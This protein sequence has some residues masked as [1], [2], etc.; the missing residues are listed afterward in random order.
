[1]ATTINQRL[2]EFVEEKKIIPSDIYS[3]IGV[4]RIQW[5]NWFNAGAPISLGKLQLIIG[6]LP[7]VNVRW[8][9]TGEIANGEG[10]IVEAHGGECKECVA[11]QRQIDAL[12][13]H[14]NTLKSM[15]DLLRKK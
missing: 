3:K 4:T 6:L 15:I 13:D 7:T 1:M 14:N 10:E 9:M 8:L 12:T 5:S 11:K 2:K